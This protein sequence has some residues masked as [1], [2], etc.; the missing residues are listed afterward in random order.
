MTFATYIIITKLEKKNETIC[1]NNFMCITLLYAFIPI[2]SGFN[3]K[4]KILFNFDI[5]TINKNTCIL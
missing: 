5:Y 3:R 2:P 1:R 4:N